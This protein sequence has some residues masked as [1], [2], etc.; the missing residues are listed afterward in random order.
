MRFFVVRARWASAQEAG[1]ERGG[2]QAEMKGVGVF[3]S[4]RLSDWDQGMGRLKA[5]RVVGPGKFL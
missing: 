4:R 3:E 1:S 2:L 5:A